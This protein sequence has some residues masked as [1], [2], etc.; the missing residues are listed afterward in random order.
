[1]GC[2]FAL[3]KALRGFLLHRY[4]AKLNQQWAERLDDSLV[5]DAVAGDDA[6]AVLH[7]SFV[8]AQRPAKEIG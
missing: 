1:M 8:V 2:Y 5:G 7:F 3:G 6:V 4:A